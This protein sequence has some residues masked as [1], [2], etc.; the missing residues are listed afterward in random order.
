[1]SHNAIIL[2]I[3][4][5]L[6]RDEGFGVHAMNALKQHIGDRPGLEFLDGGTLGMNL[7][8]YVEEASYLLVFDAVDANREGGT[9][10]EMTR[11]EIP[12]LAQIKLSPH[13]LSF[14]EVLAMAKLRGNLP[15]NLHLIGVQPVDLSIGVELS[16]RAAAAVEDAVGRAVARLA[17]WGLIQAGS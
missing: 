17:S 8:P 14:Q 3:G 16:A 4:N 13:Q 12:L 15:E 7:L 6:N 5:T 9:V 10:I 11:D 2:G 1:M